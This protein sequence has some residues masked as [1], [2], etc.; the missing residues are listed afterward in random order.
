MSEFKETKL[1]DLPLVEVRDGDGPWKKDYLLI[2][3]LS[4]GDYPFVVIS[5]NYGVQIYGQ[6]RPVKEFQFNQETCL[7]WMNTQKGN[8]VVVARNSKGLAW[9]EP[10]KLDLRDFLH[11]SQVLIKGEIK[12][13]E[14]VV[15]EWWE[16]QE[17]EE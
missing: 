10:Q 14:E 3:K 6:C 1:E 15:R 16:S 7:E 17:G 4:Y 13:L 8:G 12:P 5:Q 11:S 2:A 9:R